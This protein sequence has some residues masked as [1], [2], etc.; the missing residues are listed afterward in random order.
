LAEWVRMYQEDKFPDKAAYDM[1]QLAE[2][3]RDWAGVSQELLSKDV[4]LL[5]KR[6]RPGRGAAG[7]SEDDIKKLMRDVNS[8]ED[9]RRRA[10]ELVLAR[11]IAEVKSQTGEAVKKEAAA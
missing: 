2:D 11:S 6:K 9:L 1:R 7:I 4:K 10:E 3:Y 8:H 5:L